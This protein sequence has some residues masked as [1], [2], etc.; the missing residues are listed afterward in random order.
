MVDWVFPVSS[1]PAPSIPL[2]SFHPGDELEKI[3]FKSFSGYW[4]VLADTT[5]GLAETLFLFESGR[6]I[7]C[8]YEQL[9]SREQRWGEAAL[10][11][12]LQSL[13]ATHGVVDVVS[14]SLPQ[15]ELIPAFYSGIRL[16]STRAP[17]DLTK[18]IPTKYAMDGFPAPGRGSSPGELSRFEL[19][20]KRGLAQLHR[21]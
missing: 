9:P 11:E 4:A 6:L 2:V 3:A 1:T 20:S 10:A 18:Q 12:G 5:N 14:L 17:K 8:A 7:G 13:A 21:D 19:F 15:V 16:A